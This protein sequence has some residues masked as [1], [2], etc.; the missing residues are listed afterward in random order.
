MQL[1]NLAVAE[2]MREVSQCYGINPY[3]SRGVTWREAKEFFVCTRAYPD[4]Q[5]TLSSHT[6]IYDTVSDI[7]LNRS[8]ANILQCE[9]HHNMSGRSP[10]FRRSGTLGGAHGN[11][12]A[13]CTDELDTAHI[14]YTIYCHDTHNTGPD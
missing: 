3:L 7:Q 10:Y 6:T 2:V 12:T 1:W 5:N 11:P 14:R 4:F 13:L 9:K 8:K